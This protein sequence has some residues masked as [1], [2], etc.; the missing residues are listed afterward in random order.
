[1]NEGIDVAVISNTSQQVTP[2]LFIQE[3]NRT[4]ITTL[5]YAKCDA[6][7]RLKLW[8]NLYQN[9][10]SLNQAGLVGGDFN[11]ILN[12]EEKIGGLLVYPSE[13]EYFSYCINSC[14]LLEVSFK[15]SPFTWWNGRAATDCIF[16]RLD[17]VVIN[18]AF[19]SWLGNVEVEHLSRTG[20]DHSPLLL[21]CGEITQQIFKPFR[22]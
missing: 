10:N 22:F 18:N 7:D 6:R 21:S 9:V 3:W 11:V 8:D 20:S 15:G 5:V 17:R 13:Y 12:T 4:L 14:G 1:M 19:Q 16:K 2:K